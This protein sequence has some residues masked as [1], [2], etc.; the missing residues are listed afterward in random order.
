[1][2]PRAKD[3][4]DEVQEILALANSLFRCRLS[5]IC[6]FP[7]HATATEWAQLAWGEACRELKARYAASPRIVKI[8]TQRLSQARSELKAKV[9]PL[10]E[11]LYGFNG[12]SASHIIRQNRERA[13]N[14]KVESAFVYLHDHT[15]RKGMYRH[16]IIQKA[17][18]AMWFANKIDEGI[19]YSRFF[20]PISIQTMAFVLTAIQCAIDEWG[21]GARIDRT[22]SLKEYNPVYKNHEAN[23]KAFDGLCDNAHQILLEIRQGL[24][25]EARYSPHAYMSEYPLTP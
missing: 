3:Y 8:I 24:L 15:A 11:N 19:H 25:K 9:K 1:G 7:D 17:V 23:L 4:N 2:R 16:P 10:V 22:F 14:L 18:N 13:V 12:G 5:S 21:T 6:P 20:D